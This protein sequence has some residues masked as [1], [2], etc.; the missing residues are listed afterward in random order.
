MMTNNYTA[1]IFKTAGMERIMTRIGY[2]IF[3]SVL[4]VGRLKSSSLRLG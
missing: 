4:P 1:T 2:A 3:L